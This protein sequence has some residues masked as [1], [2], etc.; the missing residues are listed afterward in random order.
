M[1]MNQDLIRIIMSAHEQLGEDED[2]VDA[3]GELMDSLAATLGSF[4]GSTSVDPAE[5]YSRFGQIM[6][7]TLN[8]ALEERMAEAGATASELTPIEIKH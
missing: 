5:A 8:A 3:L 2:S 4:I 7:D 6:A 1:N